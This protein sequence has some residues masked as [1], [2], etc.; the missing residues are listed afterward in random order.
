MMFF[1]SYIIC[2]ST[3][4]ALF[5]KV[6][7]SFLTGNDVATGAAAK[8]VVKG[9]TGSIF[10]N[11]NSMDTI[12]MT[13]KILSTADTIQRS[14]QNENRDQRV[15]ASGA[16]VGQESLTTLRGQNSTRENSTE[17]GIHYCNI[18]K[19][20]LCCLMPNYCSKEATCKSDIVGQQTYIDYLNALPRCQC[21]PGFIG[22]G[23]TKGTGC[24][25]VNECLT[26]EARCEQLCTDYSPGYACSCNMGYRLNTKDMKSCIDIDECKEGSHNCS[27]ICVNTRGSFLCECPK[28]YILDKNQQD[29]VDIDECKENSGLGACE[30]GCKNLPGGFECQCP[31]G[32]RLDKKTQKCIDID[33]CKEEK[34]LCTGFGEV[35]FNKNGGFECKCGN[36]FQYDETEKVCKDID[37]CLFNTHDCKKDSVCVNEDGSFSCKCLEK[38]FGF[39]NEKRICE[40]IDE[41]SNGDSKCD[42]LCF[43]TIGGYKCGCYKGF[44]LN[45]TGPE[46]NRLETQSRVCVDIDEC[47]ESPEL[48]GCSH[49]CINKRGGFQCTCPKGFQ[50]GGDGKSCEDIDECRMPENPCENNRQFPCCLNTLGGFTCVEQVIIGDLFKRH[51]CPKAN[52]NY[53]KREGPRTGDVGNSSG[54]FKWFRPNADT[55]KRLKTK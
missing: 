36:G 44:R 37:E 52:G 50:L 41:C 16:E 46:E 34:N 21:L 18:D 3:S 40:D 23:R 55:V 42:Q 13:A 5:E 8:P 35:C 47:L 24:Q 12:L 20:G 29:C 48:T 10:A 28:G 27:H 19:D 31:I 7:G 22:D 39:N 9:N 30:F 49:G 11:A 43:N 1:I 45:L 4:L 38:G 14:I 26:G 51:E 53:I 2:I 54:I 33:E 32:Y 17:S 25:N 15:R 6:D